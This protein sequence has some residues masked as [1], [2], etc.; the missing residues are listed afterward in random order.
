MAEDLRRFAAGLPIRAR[1]VGVLEKSWRW[2]YRHPLMAA[3][4]VIIAAAIAVAGTTITSLQN[5]NKRLAGFRPVRITST[6]S[7][8]RIA[9]VPIDPNTNEPDPEPAGIVRPAEAT[10]LT[11]ELRGG[12]YLVEA[13]VTGGNGPDFVEVYRSVADPSGVSDVIARKNRELGL[14]P[15]TCLFRDIAILPQPH[16]ISKMVEI[17][18]PQDSRNRNQLLPEKLYVDANQT[19]PTELRRHAVFSQ[20]LRYDSEGT[21]CISYSSAIRWAE[22][23]QMRLPSAAEYDA[24]C[25]AVKRGQSHSVRT[26]ELVPINDLFDSYPE[27]STTIQA[28]PRIGG[29]RAAI[30]LREMHVL[31]GLSRLTRF[32]RFV[33][34]GR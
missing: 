13:V 21:P 17:S 34:I 9:I 2:I 23:N 28:D 14:E 8:A 27:W 7:G 32:N 15:D 26:G 11:L 12:K 19:T 20:L 5:R 33:A 6:P 22:L 10:P 25:I 16:L 4:V 1:R 24:I 3:S 18:I 30:H 29:N 31:K